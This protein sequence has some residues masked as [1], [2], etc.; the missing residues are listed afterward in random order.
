MVAPSVEELAKKHFGRLR[1]G[2]INTDE[3]PQV[4]D[5]FQIRSVPTLAVLKDGQVVDRVS[6]AIPLEELDRW[7]EKHLPQ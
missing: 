7:V 6:G 4:A 5:R 2:K 3:N 1:V